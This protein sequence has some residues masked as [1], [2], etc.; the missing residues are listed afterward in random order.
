MTTSQARPPSVLMVEDLDADRDLFLLAF[1]EVGAESELAF[2]AS[3][4]EALRYLRNEG[5]FSDILAFPRPR[6]V[7][8]DLGLP[9]I[10]GRDVLSEV[11]EEPSLRTIPVV[12]LTMSESQLEIERCYG[13][14]AN[15]FVT[16]PVHYSAVIDVVKSLRERWLQTD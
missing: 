9:G 2:S 12:V 7:L 6:L 15:D 4:E 1:R 5:E 10:S 3:G 13:L 8:L 16:K 11:K 14:G